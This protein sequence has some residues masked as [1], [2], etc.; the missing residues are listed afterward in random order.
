MELW[1]LGAFLLLESRYLCQHTHH[2]SFEGLLMLSLL[3]LTPALF[4]M[5]CISPKHYERVAL[6]L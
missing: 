2:K 5:F 4:H 3:Q 1:H 6:T